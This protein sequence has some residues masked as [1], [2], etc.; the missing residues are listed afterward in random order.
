M[1]ARIRFVHLY[2]HSHDVYDKD[3]MSA[4]RIKNTSEVIPL[5]NQN[6]FWA[7]FVTA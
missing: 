4:P 7:L 5:E 2:S 6:F 1:T 3:H